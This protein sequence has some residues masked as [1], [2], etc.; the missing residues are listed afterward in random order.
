M[1]TIVILNNSIDDD[2]DD[3]EFLLFGTCYKISKCCQRSTLGSHT[4]SC[5]VRLN[6]CNHY[7]GFRVFLG[8]KM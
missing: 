3:E 6:H 5:L 1:S 4:H 7:L 2:D 8:V